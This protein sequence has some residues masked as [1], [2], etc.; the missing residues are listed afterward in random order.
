MRRDH[1]GKL[2]PHCFVPLLKCSTKHERDCGQCGKRCKRSHEIR[3]LKHKTVGMP[4]YC[5][6]T[7]DQGG[8][9]YG[10][11]GRTNIPTYCF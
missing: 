1:D 8:G 2:R 6:Q 4:D 7:M 3:H 11:G 5:A 9:F 10:T